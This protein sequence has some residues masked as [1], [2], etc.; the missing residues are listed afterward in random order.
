MAKHEVKG[1]DVLLDAW[2]L[3]LRE[4]PDADL[5]LI[6]DGDDA[7]RL[8]Q[9]AAGM[10]GVRFLGFVSE[11]D[12]RGVYAS[13]RVLA[14]PSR[15]E[16]FGLVAAEG[17]F[18]GAAVLGLRGTVMEELFPDGHGC[19]FAEQS[20]PESVAAALVPLLR[21]PTFA[22]EMARL[23]QRRVADVF[24]FEHFAQRFENILAERG[25]M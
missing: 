24:L 20:G 22:L 19:V 9:R 21:D 1:Q 8:K 11:Q 10:R 13:S 12:K 2:P 6:G 4:V 7:D 15:Q 3:V 25:V 5:L 17:A 23:A 18:H 14:L 16:G